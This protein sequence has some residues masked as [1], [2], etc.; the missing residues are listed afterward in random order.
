MMSSKTW[1]SWEYKVMAR[2]DDWSITIEAK[3]PETFLALL[4]WLEGIYRKGYAQ[5]FLFYLEYDMPQFVS[6]HNAM[7][8]RLA[9]LKKLI[10]L[11]FH[12]LIRVNNITYVPLKDI[13]TRE[14][15][16][17]RRIIMILDAFN[18]EIHR[19]RDKIHSFIYPILRREIEKLLKIEVH[20]IWNRKYG[21]NI[22]KVSY[23]VY[24]DSLD[25]YFKRVD[26]RGYTQYGKRLSG[27]D[28][29]NILNKQLSRKASPS[30]TPD[31]VEVIV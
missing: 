13:L 28:V 3:T 7:D 27:E 8:R 9:R 19:I 26:W 25:Y 24:S 18:N 11:F 16:T 2:S 4:D 17:L 30:S 20:Y 21:E 6:T 15:E 14:Y 29:R 10:N 31:I 22:I 23:S 5:L 1:V 12:D